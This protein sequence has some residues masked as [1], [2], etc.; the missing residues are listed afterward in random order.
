MELMTLG[1]THGQPVRCDLSSYQKRIYADSSQA[2]LT[3]V[4][5][6]ACLW[7]QDLLM[8]GDLPKWTLPKTVTSAYFLIF[9]S[10]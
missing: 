1:Y 2:Q 5:K 7:I 10:G 9:D 3:T 4:G 6:R 8:V